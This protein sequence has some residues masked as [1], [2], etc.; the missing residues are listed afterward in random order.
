[1]SRAAS[2]LGY[3]VLVPVGLAARVVRDPLR[4][5]RAPKASNWR[6]TTPMPPGLAY[7]RRSDR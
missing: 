2:L 4:V 6:P 7:A 1:M 3:A 5:R